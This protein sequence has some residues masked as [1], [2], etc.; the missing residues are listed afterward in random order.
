MSPMRI[1]HKVNTHL[2]IY[3]GKLHIIID[4]NVLC[5][6]IYHN[7]CIFYFFG[8]FFLIESKKKYVRFRA[9]TQD[10][11]IKSHDKRYFFAHFVYNCTSYMLR[12]YLI[13]VWFLILISFLQ[14]AFLPAHTNVLC[15]HVSVNKWKRFKYKSNISVT[16]T[17]KRYTP[18][19]KQ[20]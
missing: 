6:I 14:F 19:K 9:Y 1:S 12:M 7:T 5:C 11:V 13:I 15:H 18:L 20:R 10:L 4:C 2:T 17:K 3:S 16:K 8:N